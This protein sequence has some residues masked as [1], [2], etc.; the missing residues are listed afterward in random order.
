MIVSHRRSALAGTALGLLLLMTTAEARPANDTDLGEVRLTRV[1][2]AA[3]AVVAGLPMRLSVSINPG[4]DLA[5]PLAARLPLLWRPGG[6]EYVGRMRVRHREAEST[7][8]I[9]GITMP[10]TL[11]TQ[12]AQCCGGRDGA[13]GVSDLPWSIIRIGVAGAEPE[14]RFPFT[15]TEQSGLSIPWRVG[16]ETIHIVVAPE[17]SE[18]IATASAAA[19]L[20]RAFGARLGDEA[21]EVPVAYGI[22]RPVRN[23]TL[24]RPAMLLGF[25]LDHI[26]VRIGDYAGDTDLPQPDLSSVPSPDEIVV[27]HKPAP[28]Q[29]RWAAITIGRDLLDR[30]SQISVYR[31]TEQIGLVCAAP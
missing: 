1:D 26:G 31:R 5:A 15:T 6:I 20:A 2:P 24:G 10:T 22:T 11:Q 3:D 25:R 13:I 29:F 4:L 16:R 7:V 19:I 18:T 8:T 27:R 21:H 23:M 30:C 12:D 9:A 17:A 28:P 14:Q